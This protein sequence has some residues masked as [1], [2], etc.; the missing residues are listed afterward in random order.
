MSSSSTQGQRPDVVA[1]VANERMLRL[2]ERLRADRQSPLG[3]TARRLA[4]DMATPEIS[5]R[6]FTESRAIGEAKGLWIHEP[7]VESDSVVLYLH[8]GGFRLGSPRSHGNLVSHIV[9]GAG[10]PAYMVDYRRSPEWPFPAALDDCLAAY[11]GLIKVG[12][13]TD[14][15]ALVGDSAGGGLVFS[16]ALRLKAAGV[17]LPGC[18]AV[19]SPWADLTGTSPTR[20]ENAWKDPICSP[21]GGAESAKSYLDGHPADDPLVSPALAS[22]FSGLPPVLIQVGTEEI[23]I[24]DALVL[25]EKCRRDEVVTDLQVGVDL[26]HVHQLYTDDLPEASEWLKRVARFVRHHLSREAPA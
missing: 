22:D 7:G 16:L 12:F 11:L 6:Y 25:A 20:T 3:L 5:D 26:I 10:C 9:T 1:N 18:L 14:K 2:V 8:G 13:S 24:R 15:I 17:S 4:F 23:L 21:Q 19:M